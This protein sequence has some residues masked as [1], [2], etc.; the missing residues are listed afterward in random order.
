MRQGKV[1]KEE[2]DKQEADSRVDTHPIGCNINHDDMEQ[3]AKELTAKGPGKCVALPADLQKLDE[4][5][6]L[7]EELSKH[8]KRKSL[9]FVFTNIAHDWRYT[10]NDQIWTF[11]STT[12]VL[13]GMPAS[14][15]TLTLHSR[16]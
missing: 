1:I 12:P 14:M 6:R 4:V 8:E 11:W 10:T 15:I 2:K 3:V 9:K 13:T 7:V 16:R 5:N